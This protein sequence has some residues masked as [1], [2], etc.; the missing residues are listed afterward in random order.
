MFFEKRID[1]LFSLTDSTFEKIA[2]LIFVE[3][4]CWLNN[5]ILAIYLQEIDPKVENDDLSNEGMEGFLS[6]LTNAIPG[7]DEAMSFAEMLK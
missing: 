7:V 5:L 1:L 6:E 4:E 2:Y 3:L